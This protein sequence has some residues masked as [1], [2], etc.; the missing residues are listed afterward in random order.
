LIHSGEFMTTTRVLG[1]ELKLART[2]SGLSQAA[3]A[4]KAGLSLPTVGQAERSEGRF[5]SFTKLAAA[6]GLTVGSR[7]PL[8]AGDS[9]G[10]QLATYRVRRGQ[11]SQR[12]MAA[13]AGITPAT[14]AAIESGKVGHL[15]ALEAVASVLGVVLCLEKSG[16]AKSFFTEGGN[17]SLHECWT[18]PA[19]VL[20]R[21]YAVIGGN[22][23]LD[24][25]SPTKDRSR[26]P[27]H[28]RHYHTLSG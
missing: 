16:R 19:W 3:L 12:G 17:A 8:P 26:A 1:T 4:D 5:E 6:L 18:T 2:A 13:A 25:C 9:I 27:V 10:E 22:F 11:H 7:T 21:L 20:D 28:A 14:V 24:P 23:D 15:S